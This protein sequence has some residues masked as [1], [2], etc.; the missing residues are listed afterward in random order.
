V[1][2]APTW[3]G[4]EEGKN[5]GKPSARKSVERLLRTHDL[6]TQWDSSHHCTRPALHRNHSH[7]V[8]VR[9]HAI[10][11]G[12]AQVTKK[13][14][15]TDKSRLS[16]IPELP[17]TLDW[18]RHYRHTKKKILYSQNRLAKI[19]GCSFYRT[20]RPQNIMMVVLPKMPLLFLLLSVKYTLNWK[21]KW[22]YWFTQLTRSAWIISNQ[23]LSSSSAT[24]KQGKKS[25]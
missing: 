6:V 3:V 19:C 25:K 15:Q 24:V 22:N 12:S 23:V 5:R 2:E 1:P 7:Y 14:W 20:S 13:T 8:R 10:K 18:T 4:S 16:F 9:S 11:Y 17:A 21:N